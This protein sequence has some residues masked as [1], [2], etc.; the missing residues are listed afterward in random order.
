MSASVPSSCP[1]LPMPSHAC[2]GSR[3]LPGQACPH[4]SPHMPPPP[5]PR[6][7]QCRGGSVQAQGP[8]AG[9]L[10]EGAAHGAPRAAICA[11]VSPGGGRPP[12][13]AQDGRR[14]AAHSARR[15]P[16]LVRV[17]AG[18]LEP[19]S[20]SPSLHF[21]LRYCGAPRLSRR[22]CALQ[23]VCPANTGGAGG[24]EGAG[25]LGLLL[26]Q[27]RWAGPQHA[28]H[29]WLRWLCRTRACSPLRSLLSPS[30]QPM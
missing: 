29:V 13:A 27:R 3:V 6:N 1:R 23:G 24:A 18:L 10:P 8:G 28:V 17:W 21:E 22:T 2:P 25:G 9:D 4:T 30:P 16:C 5:L 26:A 19:E 15:G 14:P 20:P 11:V 7:S 12:A